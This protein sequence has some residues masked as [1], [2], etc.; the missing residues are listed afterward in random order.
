VTK[1]LA[2]LVVGLIGGV[3]LGWWLYRPGAPKWEPPAPA[4]RQSDGSLILQ[5]KSDPTAKAPAQ[6]PHGSKLLRVVRVEVQPKPTLVGDGNSATV[7][8]TNRLICPPAEVDLSL[9]RNPDKTERFVASSPD[10][11]V[12]S[13]IDIPVAPIPPIPKI[14]RWSFSAL[15][16][17][18]L[19]QTRVTWGGA[20]SYSRGPIALTGG[21]IGNVLFVGAGVRF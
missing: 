10:G 2:F 13:G 20:V 9:L 21:A 12:I 6:I 5:R 4:V 11:R 1:S 19:Y 7:D 15:R 16:G 8:G 3:S 17:Y 18:D 14:P